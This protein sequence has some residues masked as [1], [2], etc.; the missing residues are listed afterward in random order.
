MHTRQ[1]IFNPF[2][3]APGVEQDARRVD[4][5]HRAAPLGARVRLGVETAESPASVEATRRR[6]M[7]LTREDL[8][9]VLLQATDGI[10]RV[11]V[12]RPAP[13]EKPAASPPAS[14]PVPL[15][16]T[17][18]P[19]GRPDVRAAQPSAYGI[20]IQPEEQAPLP[21]EESSLSP[22]FVS[23]LPRANDEKPAA[24]KR[25]SI[26]GRREPAAPTSPREPSAATRQAARTI[27]NGMQSWR[28]GMERTKQGLQGFM[29]R[30]LPGA[31]QNAWTLSAPALAFIAIL[32][33][34]VVVTVATVVYFRYGRS[35]QYEEYLVQAKDARAQ[36]VGLTD[37]AAQ[38]EAWQRVLFYLDKA[39]S[40]S[41]GSDT[42]A[43]REEAQQKLD[44]LQGI[45]RLQFQPVLSSGLGTQISRLAAASCNRCR[46]NPRPSTVNDE[47]PMSSNLFVAQKSLNIL[48][49][50]R[51]Q[52]FRERADDPF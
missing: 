17:A 46:T 20:P 52:N 5:R 28:A 42:R 51:A 7:S 25:R 35:V 32:V 23:A 22:E 41:Q 12:L 39:E 21:E 44:G 50:D 48:E 9:A 43:L 36:A 14:A 47:S 37:A 18:M 10:G 33:P 26:F 24:P 15:Q 3:R 34:L 49:H 6:L 38:R 11:S 31:D 4:A 8:S 30:L 27:T 40:Y 29:P 2:D 19:V 13:E 16:P 1:Q 45:F